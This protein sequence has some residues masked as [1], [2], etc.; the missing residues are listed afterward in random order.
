MASLL[1]RSS[2]SQGLHGDLPSS[3]VTRLTDLSD[4]TFDPSSHL[5]R[6]SG[7]LAPLPLLPGAE[8]NTQKKKKQKKINQHE[9]TSAC[10]PTRLYTIF[11]RVSAGAPRSWRLRRGGMVE[12]VH[13][14]LEPPL[15]VLRHPPAPP[16]VCK[17]PRSTRRVLSDRSL[18]SLN[19]PPGRHH[20]R[21][22]KIPPAVLSESSPPPLTN[23][24]V[25]LVSPNG[26]SRAMA[27][28][29]NIIFKK[30]PEMPKVE[31]RTN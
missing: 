24:S 26:P 4:S 15:R 17:Q 20:R 27:R 10:T 28:S 3:P 14:S 21:T 7:V 11:S 2:R 5:R 9:T 30:N 25:L 31:Y 16:P 22:I 12:L 1:I 23:A 18:R 19:P 13:D 29:I 6:F 8:S